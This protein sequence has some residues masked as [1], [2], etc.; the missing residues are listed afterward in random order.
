M[1]RGIDGT[2]VA[3]PEQGVMDYHKNAAPCHSVSAYLAPQ[4]CKSVEASTVKSEAG[5]GRS[6][7]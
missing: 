3:L 5:T 6:R 4:N 7:N 1:V 2:L